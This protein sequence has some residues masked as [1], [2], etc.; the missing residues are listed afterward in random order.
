ME[1][2]L[3]SALVIIQHNY[4]IITAAI[5]IRWFQK[6]IHTIQ[7]FWG[8]KF[9]HISSLLLY[10]AD[11]LVL[12][13]AS[14]TSQDGAPAKASTPTIRTSTKGK[15]NKKKLGCQSTNNNARLLVY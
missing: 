8:Q 9:R 2:V 3:W 14:V 15:N 12:T 11:T 4:K 13:V 1:F 6:E 5:K 10:W 7:K